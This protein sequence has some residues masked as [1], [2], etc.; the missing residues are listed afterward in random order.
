MI[1]AL[2]DLEAGALPESMRAM[3]ISERPSGMQLLSSHPPIA[4]RI[5][6]L[7][8]GEAK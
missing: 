2:N 8:A 7:Q 5:S 4:E 3:G 1:G 6:A